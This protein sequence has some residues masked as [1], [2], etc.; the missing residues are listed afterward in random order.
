M[1]SL[2][3]APRHRHTPIVL[4]ASLAVASMAGQAVR[5]ESVASPFT[6]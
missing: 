2:A 5:T 1:N 3:A 4:T 6:P